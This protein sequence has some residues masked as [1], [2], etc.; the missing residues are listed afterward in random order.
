MK[1]FEELNCGVKVEDISVVHRNGKPKKDSTKKARPILVK[2]TSRKSKG[3]VMKKRQLLK[4]SV[5]YKRVYLNDDLTP[6]RSRLL[7]LAKNH[8]AVQRVSTT[9]DGKIICHMRKK[10]GQTSGDVVYLDSPDDLFR[11]GLK[12]VDYRQLGLLNYVSSA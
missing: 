8:D 12:D 6:L 2:F 7:H 5:R 10:T 3:A 11:L 1:L 4:E 9:H